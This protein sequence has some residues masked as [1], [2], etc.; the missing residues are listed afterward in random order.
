MPKGKGYSLEKDIEHLGKRHEKARAKLKPKKK[1]EDWVARLKR[2]V[3][4]MLQG[5][6]YKVPKKK[7][8]NPSKK[9]GY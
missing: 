8:N 7:K 3:Q 9:A 5:K 1:K 6:H 4:M 2:Q